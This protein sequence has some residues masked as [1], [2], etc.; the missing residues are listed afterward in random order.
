MI[1]TITKSKVP[2]LVISTDECT[3]TDMDDG[4]R[5]YDLDLAKLPR[6]E[7]D[8]D[9]MNGFTE[10]SEQA[11]KDYVYEFDSICTAIGDT[12][13]N[14]PISGYVAFNN[15]FLKENSTFEIFDT[16]K[17]A[18]KEMLQNEGI[19]LKYW[20]TELII[21]KTRSHG[22]GLNSLDADEKLNKAF[23]DILIIKIKE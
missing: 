2:F 9:S 4:K 15:I 23:N 22:A 20:I 17:D 1:K 5:I 6:N 16:A 13:P 11:C 3:Y 21:I 8:W 7:Y 12:N 19:W 18:L 14:K 10:L